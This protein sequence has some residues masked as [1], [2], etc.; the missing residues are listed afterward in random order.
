MMTTLLIT[1]S[2]TASAAAVDFDVTTPAGNGKISGLAIG[3]AIFVG[4]VVYWVKCR[5][6]KCS[7]GEDDDEAPPAKKEELRVAEPP[8]AAEGKPEPAAEGKPDAAGAA[9]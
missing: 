9:V 4:L 3:L 7:S 5:A 6:A 8:A 2:S 1:D